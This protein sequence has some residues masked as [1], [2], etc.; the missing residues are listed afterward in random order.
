MLILFDV[1]GTLTPSRGTIDPDFRLWLETELRHPFRLITG[2]D[3]AKTQ[4]Q[5]GMDFWSSNYCYN[6]AGNH[7]FDSGREVYRSGWR[8]PTDLE[9]ILQGKLTA[10]RWPTRTG[11][12]FEHR[13]GLCNFSVVGRN[14]SKSQ[15]RE[16]FEW[17]QSAGEREQIATLI[18]HCWKDV[19]ASVAGET[20]IDIYARGT[21]KEHILDQI[22]QHAPIHFFGDRQDPAGNDFGLAQTILTRHMGT[23]YHVKD[24]QHTWQLLKELNEH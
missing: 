18:N 24:W 14:A 5:L 23:C 22:D 13:V 1:D 7:V 4:E 16:Y 11:L 20:G 6:C 10:S 19:Q 3:A 12:H 2:S 9:W 8:I 17:D 21:G 15:R